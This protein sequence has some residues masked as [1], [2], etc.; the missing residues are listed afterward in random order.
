MEKHGIK[1]LREALLAVKEIAV[2]GKKGLKLFKKIKEDGIGLEDLIYI[3][4]LPELAPEM[5]IITAGYED[6]SKAVEEAKDLDEAEVMELVALVF[7]IIK[8]IKEE[9]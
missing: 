9:E 3:K 6:I 7:A 2:T 5:D 8:A 1:E 4:E